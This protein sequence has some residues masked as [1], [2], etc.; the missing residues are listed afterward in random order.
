MNDSVIN[1][2]FPQI[3]ATLEDIKN[4]INTLSNI[5]DDTDKAFANLLNSGAFEGAAASQVQLVR[6][7]QS[8]QTEEYIATLTQIHQQAVQQ[9]YDTMSLDHQ[10]AGGIGGI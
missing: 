8:H 5:R 6:Q 10:L 1:H 4:G 2:Q 3:F 7:H 9:Q